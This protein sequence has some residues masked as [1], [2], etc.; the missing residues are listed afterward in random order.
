MP[1]KKTKHYVPGTFVPGTLLCF[2]FYP[3]SDYRQVGI[4]SHRQVHPVGIYSGDNQYTTRCT[5]RSRDTTKC[6][7]DLPRA[8]GTAMTVV[9]RPPEFYPTECQTLNT[10]RT[11]YEMHRYFARTHILITL[12]LACSQ[13]CI[14]LYDPGHDVTPVVRTVYMFMPDHVASG[15][16]VYLFSQ[17]KYLPRRMISNIQSIL[18][19]SLF[20]YIPC[21]S[22]F[23][24][25]IYIYI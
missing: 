1:R 16:I 7:R 3:L 18:V 11:R 8:G 22:L 9:R 21:I 6:F 14:I 19:R 24:C 2:T 15:C 17:T 13:T 4:Y 20:G 12:V 5:R 10:I 25:N 23:S